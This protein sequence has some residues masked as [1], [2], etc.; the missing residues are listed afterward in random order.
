MQPL[1]P[2]SLPLA[3]APPQTVDERIAGGQTPLWAERMGLAGSR[4]GAQSAT[5]YGH[6]SEYKPSQ[7]TEARSMVRRGP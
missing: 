7:K 2:S 5:I 4:Q 6:R 3:A 1:N